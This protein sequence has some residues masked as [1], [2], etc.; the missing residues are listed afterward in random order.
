MVKVSIEHMYLRNHT[1][2]SYYI[3]SITILLSTFSTCNIYYGCLVNYFRIRCP[4]ALLKQVKVVHTFS[5]IR[6]FTYNTIP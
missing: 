2:Y 1:I 4:I 6:Q 3:A 5:T